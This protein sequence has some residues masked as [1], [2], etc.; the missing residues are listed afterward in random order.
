MRSVAPGQIIECVLFSG[1]AGL[2]IT[3]GRRDAREGDPRLPAT[4]PRSTSSS[5]TAGGTPW[6]ASGL[7]QDLAR[8]GLKAPFVVA[9]V[10][11]P[12][13]VRIV[14]DVVDCPP[15]EVGIGMPLSVTYRQMD[16]ELILPMWAPR[17]L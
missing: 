14:G 4:S 2:S 11:L 15:G 3:A 6:S 17:E 5:G 7:Q 8:P 12:E 10:E 13:G 16:D 1:A 9:V